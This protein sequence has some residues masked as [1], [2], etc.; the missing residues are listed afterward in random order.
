MNDDLNLL[1]TWAEALLTKLSPAQRR[2]LFYHIAQDLRRSQAHRI[3][4]QQAPDGTSYTPRKHRKNLRGKRGRIKRQKT[5]MFTK[6]RT[7]KYLKTQSDANQLTVGFYGR[8]ARVARVHQ[9]GLKDKVARNGAEYRYPERQLLGFNL[10]DHRFIRESL[11][12]HFNDIQ[13]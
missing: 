13:G 11:L 1:A 5:E 6:L 3:K 9:E 10:T 8:V 7:T 2:Q 12:H 4:G